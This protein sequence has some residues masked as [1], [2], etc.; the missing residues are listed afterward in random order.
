VLGP[1]NKEAFDFL[2]ETAHFCFV[3]DFRGHHWKCTAN[4]IDTVDYANL[5]TKTF[6]WIV[7]NEGSLQWNYCLRKIVTTNV[8]VM[9]SIEVRVLKC[10]YAQCQIKGHYTRHNNTQ[11]N[12]LIYDT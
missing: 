5:K 2:N 11:Q 8:C 9:I 4:A 3:I 12:G 7:K 1:E 6:V 10:Y